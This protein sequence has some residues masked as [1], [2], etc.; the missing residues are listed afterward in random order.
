MLHVAL[1]S[2]IKVQALSL[3]TPNEV[4]MSCIDSKV[5]LLLLLLLLSPTTLSTLSLIVSIFICIIL[6]FEAIYFVPFFKFLVHN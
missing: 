4:K 2:Y 5:G 6:H 1:S 3:Y